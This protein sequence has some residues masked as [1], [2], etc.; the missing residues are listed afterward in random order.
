MSP[1]V[2]AGIIIGLIAATIVLILLAC[3]LLKITKGGK[4]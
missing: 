3:F 2:V 1:A 4:E